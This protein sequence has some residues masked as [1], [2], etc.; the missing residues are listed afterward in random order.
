MAQGSANYQISDNKVN[1]FCTLSW[2]SSSGQVNFTLEV[3]NVKFNC[4][5]GAAPGDGKR[6]LDLLVDNVQH[7]NHKQVSETP[8]GTWQTGWHDAGGYFIPSTTTFSVATKR[9]AYAVT[10]KNCWSSGEATKT[11]TDS[12]TINVAP[13]IRVKTADGWEAV[14][15]VKVGGASVETVKVK[16]ADGWEETA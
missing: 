8:H 15:E 11:V 7:I 14:E 13:D 6:Y 12:L 3:T 5:G 16:T 1:I 2:V 9:E 10:L 4:S